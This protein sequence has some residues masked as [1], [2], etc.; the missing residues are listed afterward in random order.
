V[1]LSWL[2]SRA[3]DVSPVATLISRGIFPRA[4]FSGV[5]FGVVAGRIGRSARPV[6]D[7]DEFRDGATERVG[8][9]AGF[10]RTFRLWIKGP[11]THNDGL[12]P[13]KGAVNARADRIAV[14][15]W[16]WHQLARAGAGPCH[17]HKL[18]ILECRGDGIRIVRVDGEDDVE[19]I[20]RPVRPSVSVSRAT[21]MC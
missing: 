21:A 4:I 11:I 12:V 3:G 18:R 8:Y 2:T 15:I 9:S 5:V 16:T 14:A 13:V 6:D 7:R 1:R 20:G 19:V 10:L 17:S